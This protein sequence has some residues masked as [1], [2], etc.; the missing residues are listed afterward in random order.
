MKKVIPLLLFA[1]CLFQTRAQDD[2]CSFGKRLTKD[3]VEAQQLYDQKQYAKSAALLEQLRSD[4]NLS[5]SD[6]KGVG[7]LYNL[8]CDY[9]LLGEKDKALK[10][11]GDA[12]AAG[13]TN[14]DQMRDD[15][16]LANIRE[17]PEYK[18]LFAVVES[19]S[20]AQAAF[21]DGPSLNTK[22]ADNLTEDEK[23][24]G[25]SRLWSEAKYNFVY[26]DRL[27]NL[28]WDAT[29]LAY[30]PKVRASKTTVEYYTI[31]TEFYAQLHD[32]HTAVGW[33]REMRQA[34]GYPAISTRLVEGRVFID[35]V[36]DPKLAEDGV[37]LGVEILAIDGVPVKDYG[38]THIAPLVS[39]SSPQD[40][41]RR[42]YE[43]QLLGGPKDSPVELT[44]QD[45]AGTTK[46][47]KLPRLTPA[48]AD[49]LPP[50]PWKRFKFKM[51]PGKVAYAAMNAFGSKA[52]VKE[53]D[54]AFPE[55]Q[56]SKALILDVREN[57]GGSSNIGYEIL[58]YLT[59]KPFL[60]SQWSTRDYRPTYRAWGR[61]DRWYAEAAEPISAHGGEPYTQP[62]VVLTS[63]ETYSAAE[64]FVVAFDTMKRGTIIG[65]P[66]GGSTGQPLFFSLPGGGFASVCS[67]HDQYPDGREFVGVGVQP[68]V[69][70]HPTVADFREGRDTVL[71][72]ALQFVTRRQ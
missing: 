53:F 34:S 68:Q 59:S 2:E 71:N 55:I 7:L 57:G 67:K 31:L 44:I 60:G 58:G 28:D 11:L 61:P 10:A 52:I 29:Y 25:L 62:I 21:W 12:V 51:L 8:A 56:K 1:V 40:R 17:E 49:K 3:M 26:F 30:L 37:G 22:Y 72:A 63:A 66:T 24:A 38:A 14:A 42:T 54:A 43:A 13:L 23:I 46:K 32:G 16:D 20:K 65:E 35:F 9:S 69:L 6:N 47:V 27:P 18:K 33:P 4:P 19:R 15:T 45:A 5:H 39:A 64:D 36:R 70:V 50:E 41:D 48:Q